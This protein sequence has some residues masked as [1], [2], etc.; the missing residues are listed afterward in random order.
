MSYRLPWVPPVVP[1]PTRWERLRDWW[2]E[3]WVIV[4]VIVGTLGAIVSIGV[5]AYLQPPPAP[6]LPPRVIRQDCWTHLQPIPAGKIM[7]LVPMRSCRQ[8]C[9]NP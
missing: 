7:I 2:R 9:T 3:Y 4:L 8:I 6:C 1:G 5:V